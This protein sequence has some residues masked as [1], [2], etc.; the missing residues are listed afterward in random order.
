MLRKP[1]EL[2]PQVA[3][4]FVRDIRRFFKEGA[5][6]G[7]ERSRLTEG[8]DLDQIG[9]NFATADIFP[10]AVSRTF[11][12]GA[13]IEIVMMWACQPARLVLKHRV[14]QG[15]AQAGYVA[16]GPDR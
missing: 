13:T 14:F 10:N 11:D 2:P 4:A 15:C 9:R 16:C 7:D 1:I 8:L 6:S 3:K 5:V 12:F